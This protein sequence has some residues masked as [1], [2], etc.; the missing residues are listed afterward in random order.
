MAEFTE[1]FYYEYPID[2]EPE[3]F[4]EPSVRSIEDLRRDLRSDPASWKADLM[5]TLT[6][7]YLPA[8]E[9]YEQ[10][11]IMRKFRYR[12]EDPDDDSPF[13][14]EELEEELEFLT[15]V[16]EADRERSREMIESDFI[17]EVRMHALAAYNILDSSEDYEPS[18]KADLL[19]GYEPAP[20]DD[21]IPRRLYESAESLRKLSYQIDRLDEDEDLAD[22]RSPFVI[23]EDI[24]EE[25]L[26][27]ADRQLITKDAEHK[28]DLNRLFARKTELEDELMDLAESML[29]DRSLWENEDE[30]FAEDNMIAIE[31]LGEEILNMQISRAAV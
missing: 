16:F 29:Q 22:M 21:R 5:A 27:T 25:S 8:R 10:D 15:D 4:E 13:S 3:E 2:Y 18:G 20:E 24:S 7:A 12:I 6:E 1:D 14:R 26:T 28:R 19:E 30:I 11:E 17:E 23:I 9:V 31:E